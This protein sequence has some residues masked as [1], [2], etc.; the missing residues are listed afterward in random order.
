MS[1][2]QNVHSVMV[3]FVIKE[4]YYAV[5]GPASSVQGTQ[6]QQQHQDADLLLGKSSCLD[7]SS[8]RCLPDSNFG[9]KVDLHFIAALRAPRAYSERVA[10]K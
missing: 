4:R 8:P 5:A 2:R 6:I 9:S 3:S 10:D 7:C 1:N